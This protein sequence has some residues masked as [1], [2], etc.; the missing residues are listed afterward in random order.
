VWWS[1]I[2]VLFIHILPIKRAD[3]A[4]PNLAIQLQNDCH[5]IRTSVIPAWNTSSW[6]HWMCLPDIRYITCVLWWHYPAHIEIWCLLCTRAQLNSKELQESQI[7]LILMITA[8][9]HS[10]MFI[11]C[12]DVMYFVYIQQSLLHRARLN[13]RES[14][15]SKIQL[16]HHCRRTRP[17]RHQ[18]P[19][20][21]THWRLLVQLHMHT[22]PYKHPIHVE[23]VY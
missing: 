16:R 13:S 2:Y 12:W 15:V 18:I 23:S 3:L 14:Q 17:Y 6:S 22:R 21:N 8:F 1:L 20:F 11:G 10:N 19:T 4:L 7:W 9:I 5:K